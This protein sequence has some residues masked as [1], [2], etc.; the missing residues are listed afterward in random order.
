MDKLNKRQA[1]K[2]MRVFLT[3]RHEFS[4]SYSVFPK[5]A[6]WPGNR[7]IPISG[8]ARGKINGW[9]SFKSISIERWAGCFKA[10]VKG[11]AGYMVI[12]PNLKE[13]WTRGQVDHMRSFGVTRALFLAAK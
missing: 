13:S 1:P 9:L 5:T 6:A 3:Y 2:F 8:S 10:R 4:Y 12:S 7:G 11:V